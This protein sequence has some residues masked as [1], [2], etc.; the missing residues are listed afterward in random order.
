MARGVSSCARALASALG[1][2][3]AKDRLSSIG[4]LGLKLNLMSWSEGAR[5]RTR[6]V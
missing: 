5:E 6:W 2:D 1:R 4:S 3:E